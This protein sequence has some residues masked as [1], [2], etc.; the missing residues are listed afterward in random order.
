MS[1]FLAQ[2]GPDTGLPTAI[3]A[4]V[5]VLIYAGPLLFA[6]FAIWAWRRDRPGWSIAARSPPSARL[7]GCS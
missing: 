5:A 7:W 3:E 2:A 6:G 4:L 1:S